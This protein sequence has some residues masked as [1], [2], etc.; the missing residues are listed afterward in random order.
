MKVQ[1]SSQGQMEG[2]T[3]QLVS[4]SNM[5]CNYKLQYMQ[6]TLSFN[7]SEANMKWHQVVTWSTEINVM[8][9]E[10]GPFSILVC[11]AK[12]VLCLL[13]ICRWNGRAGSVWAYAVYYSASRCVFLEAAFSSMWSE[14]RN[15]FERQQWEPVLATG[16]VKASLDGIYG[17]WD[18]VGKTS[19]EI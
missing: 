5:K 3:S 9:A 8:T 2:R 19:P 10:A 7:F 18:T 4:P 15:P 6:V 17:D 11:M 1:T 14:V 16:T 12:V 13:T